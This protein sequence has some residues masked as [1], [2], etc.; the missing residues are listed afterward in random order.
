MTE[1]PTTAIPATEIPEAALRRHAARVRGAIATLTLAVAAVGAAYASA[2]L[3]G[4]APAWAAWAFALAMPVAVLALLV[5]GVS[6]PGHGIG[7]L[8]YPFAF[9]FVVLVAGFS[10]ALL[11]PPPAADSPLWLGLPPGA[12]VI[13]Y[14]VGILPL[15]VLPM[16]YA[17]TFDRQTLS[18]ADLE[19]VRAA[20]AALAREGAGVAGVAGGPPRVEGSSVPPG[21]A[22]RSTAVGIAATP[23]RGVPTA[24]A[25]RADAPL[26]A[27]PRPESR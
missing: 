6:R 9:V 2:F 24:S 14:G 21:T 5:L 19:R 22:H 10:T 16:A 12:A 3:P 20:A 18:A 7:R 25:E 8:A 1:I 13:L 17:L 15:F 11:L 27:V 23:D 4:G 26:A